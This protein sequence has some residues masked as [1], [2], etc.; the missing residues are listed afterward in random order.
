[1]S[2]T[3]R[4]DNDPA[5]Q[6]AAE[7][8]ARLRAMRGEDLVE[9]AAQLLNTYVVEGVLPLQRA[10][11]TSDLANDTV[12][13]ETFAQ[14]LKRMKVAK[15]DPILE[16]F[17]IDGENI[18]VRIEGQ[19][20]MPITDYRRPTGT[21]NAAGQAAQPQPRR[22]GAPGA[23]T[24]IYN[25]SLYQP[26]QQQGSSA[27]AAPVRTVAPSVQP[28]PGAQQPQRPAASQPPSGPAQ[29]PGQKKPDDQPK[30]DRF[31]L[32]ELE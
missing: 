16:R 15:R 31:A 30:N 23:A 18:S 7:L 8:R 22:E 4:N 10:G 5:A 11:E 20:V 6:V 21:P 26:E 17:F 19:G 9:L 2:D 27:P 1:M 3:P 12:G 29:Q 25:R 14:M 32:I 24:S 13:E 28:M